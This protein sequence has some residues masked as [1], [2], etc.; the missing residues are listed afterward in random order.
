MQ[1]IVWFVL[2]NPIVLLK[3]SFFKGNSVGDSTFGQ[4]KVHGSAISAESLSLLSLRD[5]DFTENIV[6]LNSGIQGFGAVSVESAQLVSLLRVSLWNNSVLSSTLTSNNS[7]G[8]LFVRSRVNRVDLEAVCV[9]R[10]RVRLA[11]EAP[12]TAADFTCEA[13]ILANLELRNS[14]IGSVRQCFAPQYRN[15][16]AP[17]GGKF[18]PRRVPELDELDMQSPFDQSDSDISLDESSSSSSASPENAAV[19]RLQ[20]PMASLSPSKGDSLLEN[21][22]LLAGIVAGGCCVLL[23]CIGTLCFVGKRQQKKRR[24]D[25]GDGTEIVSGVVLQSKRSNSSSDFQDKN[26]VYSSFANARTE[27]QPIDTTAEANDKGVYEQG[28]VESM[29]KSESEND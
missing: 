8:A 28:N 18:C 14:T 10:N 6:Q 25:G 21:I 1:L 19:D 26:G 9:C 11:A 5:C 3:N 24:D 27:Y 13:D 29:S 22:P 2:I 12:F 7:A 23:L 17:C 20:A 15:L 4:G 16:S